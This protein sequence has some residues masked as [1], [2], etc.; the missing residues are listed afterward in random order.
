MLKKIIILSLAISL[1]PLAM[2]GENPNLVRNGDFS[3]IKKSRLVGWE[4]YGHSSAKQKLELWKDGENPCA[5]L[6][7]SAFEVKSGSSHALIGQIGLMHPLIK[8]R[9][10]EFSCRM[11]ATNIRSKSVV[12]QI[13]N[14]K[15]WGYGGLNERV[16]VGHKWRNYKFKIWATDNLKENARVSIHF[17]ETGELYVDDVKLIE[18][19]EPA[20]E[21]TN[22][23]P[24][25]NSKNLIPNGDFGS[26][27][28][29]WT[30]CGKGMACSNLERLHG[31][32]MLEKNPA[33]NHFLRIPMGGKDTPEL[34]F[35]G[36]GVGVKKELRP[37]VQGMQIISVAK[38]QKYTF[39]CYM[40]SDNKNA[41]A[42][43]QIVERNPACHG[44]RDKTT[45]MAKVFNL[46]THWQRHHITFV[47]KSDYVT[48][49]AGPDL[50]QDSQ[51]YIDVAGLQ[52]EKNDKATSF[53]PRL[54]TEIGI[55]PTCEGG[56]FI[57]G[58][59]APAL[60]ITVSNNKNSTANGIVKFCLRDYFNRIAEVAPVNFSVSCHT[61]KSFII[62]LPDTWR[63]FFSGSAQWEIDS[64]SGET[65]LRLAIVPPPP[66]DSILGVNHTFAPNWLISQAKKAGV[67]WYRN[68][69]NWQIVEPKPGKYNFKNQDYQ[70]NRVIE[71]DAHMMSILPEN[72]S[73]NW[74]SEKNPAV[75]PTGNPY[76]AKQFLEI[77]PPKDS[78]VMSG[79]IEKVVSRYKEKV[80]VWE[81]LNEPVYGI[82]R[83]L[84]RTHYKPKA[85]YELFK[86]AAKS[87]KKIDPNCK[88][89]G[90]ISG[91]FY[92]FHYTSELI[93]MGML[94]YADITN[95]HLYPSTAPEIYLSNIKKLVA[96]MKKNNCLRPIWVTE[97]TYR[98]YDDVP[99]KPYIKSGPIDSCILRSE[100]VGADWTL[101]FFAI[102]NAHN[103]K[104][105]FIHAG[106]TTGPNGVIGGCSLFGY[107]GAP[108]KTFAALAQYVNFI[109]TN[110][111][112]VAER[113][114]DNCGYAYTF[115]SK[116]KNV[117]IMWNPDD[118]TELYVNNEK[119]ISIYDAMGNI[120][121]KKRV[122]L[123]STPIYIKTTTQ[124]AKTWLNNLTINCPSS[125]K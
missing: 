82:S 74:S 123:G 48:I 54:S 92:T 81:F 16:I 8:G 103:V 85:Y 75:K 63:G 28:A 13:R 3:Q 87:M 46:G 95:L 47:P 77:Q 93:K 89:I 38:G 113:R 107:G 120:I 98:A 102:M 24:K 40:R 37:L 53:Q 118:K 59:D 100:R 114:L 97:F 45:K 101:R 18:L 43:L 22:V 105:I 91:N 35:D 122:K 106:V 78:Q 21:F 67:L 55:M 60:K 42:A 94:K 27:T 62:K 69:I 19:P 1:C 99:R 111:K 68:W 26:G 30:S 110:F 23:V 90:G 11:R 6:T 117:I 70:I 115:E 61:S 4:V 73:A 80:K 112:F 116:G 83:G 29:H 86:V 7:C 41:R 14:I 49:G 66:T 2:F 12:I 52:L 44:N 104:K 65:K 96:L 56:V 50:K 57:K 34:C 79:F 15:N 51:L 71:R 76:R 58:K 9:L 64:I 124:R 108:T 88:V 25:T 125:N 32:L 10:Y 109:G 121:S 119:G 5:K 20:I 84:P 17:K 36:W 72:P 33:G 39:S 31:K